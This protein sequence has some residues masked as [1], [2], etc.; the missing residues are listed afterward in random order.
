MMNIGIVGTGSASK[1]H[2][3]ALDVLDSISRVF[4]F[5]RDIK[6]AKLLA[7]ECEKAEALD[8]LQ[9]LALSVDAVVIATP[10]HTHLDL[11]KKIYQYKKLPVLSEKPLTCSMQ[12]GDE[13][14][15]L[16]DPLSIVGF[17][18]RFNQP[19][20]TILELQQKYNLGDVTHITLSFKSSS[21]LTKKTIGWKD[22]TIQQGT[23]GA[24][25]DIGIHLMD[26][27][28]FISDSTI[29]LENLH[30]SLGQRIANRGGSELHQEDCCVLSGVTL[31]HIPFKLEA[32]KACDPVDVGLFLEINFLEGKA[33][34]SSQIPQKIKLEAF[35]T[36]GVN[37]IEI[38]KP[39]LKDP[40]KEV[41]YWSDSF[42]LQIKCWVDSLSESLLDGQLGSIADG[43]YA[44]KVLG[45]CVSH[46]KKA[47]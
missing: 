28:G 1:A 16:A 14:M 20:M 11:L 25:G 4:I 3:S 31:N 5:S 47:K 45:R 30:V 44:Q 9:K 24:C 12:E 35:D 42:Y 7:A 21:G 22:S 10:N 13:F 19:L 38:N 23:G 33:S 15:A 37:E 34:Y 26:L 41:A 8:S 39:L 36:P 17:N 32:S 40:V 43:C 6:K 18:Y 46:M 27:V 29:N 2:L